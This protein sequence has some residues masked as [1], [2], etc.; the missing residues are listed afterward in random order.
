MITYNI[1]VLGAPKTGKKSFVNCF[2]VSINYYI[3]TVYTNSNYGEIFINFYMGLEL[4]KKVKF[5]AVIVLFDTAD[6]ESLLYVYE[7]EL[8]NIPIVLCVTK[9]DLRD[10]GL[11]EKSRILLR[12]LSKVYDNIV[13]ES[14]VANR[15]D[16]AEILLLKLV[17]KLMLKDDLIFIKKQATKKIEIPE[18]LYE[19]MKSFYTSNKLE[20]LI[21]FHSEM[22][23]IF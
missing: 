17:R 2:D 19:K 4:D 23:N 21:N 9:I 7:L 15:T 12:K 8:P 10:G 20:E 5:D 14:I 16:Y 3:H 18:K 1:A 6:K 13:C 11:I 22:K